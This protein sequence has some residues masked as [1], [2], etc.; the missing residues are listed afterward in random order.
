MFFF[1]FN[2]IGI[3]GSIEQKVNENFSLSGG[4]RKD[5]PY[6]PY[7]GYYYDLTDKFYF[8]PQLSGTYRA[9]DN[10]SFKSSFSINYQYVRELSYSC[11]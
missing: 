8:A 6:D 2:E 11:D 7:S 5:T 4:L 9:D 1:T 3:F 10:W